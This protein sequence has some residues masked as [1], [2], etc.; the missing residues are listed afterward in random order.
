[1]LNKFISKTEHTS[2]R[3]K[4]FGK[5]VEDDVGVST[6]RK[7]NEFGIEAAASLAACGG[8]SSEDEI[9]RHAPIV[10]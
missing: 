7:D 9:E 5:F 2:L 8:S 3:Q 1:M 10:F 4:L 6:K